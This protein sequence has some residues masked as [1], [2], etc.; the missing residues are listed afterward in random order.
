M[1]CELKGVQRYRA[2]VLNHIKVDN[3]M[4]IVG[5][6]VEVGLEGKVIMARDHI[7]WQYLAPFGDIKSTGIGLYSTV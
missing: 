5:M 3:D 6:L 7:G 2:G 1:N 4:S